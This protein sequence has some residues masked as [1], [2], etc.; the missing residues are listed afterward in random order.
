LKRVEIKPGIKDVD[1]TSE[2]IALK[3]VEF[4]NDNG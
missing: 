4:V 3:A 2:E 1:Y